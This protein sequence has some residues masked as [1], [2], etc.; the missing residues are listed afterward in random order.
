MEVLKGTYRSPDYPL[1]RQAHLVLAQLTI[2]TEAIFVSE[3][4]LLGSGQGIKSREHMAQPSESYF[5]G[6]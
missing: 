6:L 2:F 5:P 4:T 1:V 3:S